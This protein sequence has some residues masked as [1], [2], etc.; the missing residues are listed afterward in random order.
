MRTFNV[1]SL[2]SFQVY[3]TV[4]LTIVIILNIRSPELIHLITESLYPLTNISLSLPLP[5]LTITNL[6]PISLSLAFFFF[7]IPH[8]SEI[9]QYLFS[10]VW[11]ISLR[12][13]HSFCHKCQDFLLFHGWIIF[14][15]VYMCVCVCVCVS[16][17][18]Y[19]IFFTHPSK[20][21][22]MDCGWEGLELSVW[23]FQ[24]LW[25]HRQECLLLGPCVAD[26]LMDM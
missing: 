8:F 20:I 1:Y 24:C 15:Y 2:S 12:M 14:H 26:L 9:I 5:T 10:S 21:R 7:K 16:I 13:F 3:S 25:E 22:L 19:H 17:Y 6:V 4:L 11:L 18:I 23:P